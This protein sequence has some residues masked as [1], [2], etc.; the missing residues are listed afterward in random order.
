MWESSVHFGDLREDSDSTEEKERGENHVETFEAD[1]F[2]NFD[3]IAHGRNFNFDL[4]DEDGD[5]IENAGDDDHN[6]IDLKVSLVPFPQKTFR[7]FSKESQIFV[8][9]IWEK[10]LILLL[11]FY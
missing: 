3:F 10:Q 7:I 2:G 4:D 1:H 6:G 8:T 5:N 11:E 9:R